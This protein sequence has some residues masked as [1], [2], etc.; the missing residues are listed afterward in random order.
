MEHIFI[1][2][3]RGGNLRKSVRYYFYLLSTVKRLYLGLHPYDHT[4][5][6]V[7]ISEKEACLSEA[8][9]RMKRDILGDRK[10]PTAERSFCLLSTR[11]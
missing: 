3:G 6:K 11:T 5:V 9:S 8:P 4:T 2:R 7:N 1:G 10:I